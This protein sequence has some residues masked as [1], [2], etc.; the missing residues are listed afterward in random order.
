[1]KNTYKTRQGDNFE[2]LTINVE[3]IGFN[4]DKMHVYYIEINAETG[5]EVDW[6]K[7]R[8]DN[9][10]NKTKALFEIMEAGFNIEKSKKNP[11]GFILKSSK[12]Y[13][14]TKIYFA[15]EDLVFSNI[16]HFN[17]SS[18]YN[19]VTEQFAEEMQGCGCLS[20][21][22]PFFINADRYE[23]HLD[24]FY[25][26][27]TNTSTYRD[28]EENYI[29]EEVE[30]Y[31]TNTKKMQARINSDKDQIGWDLFQELEPDAAYNL[32]KAGQNNG[33]YFFNGCEYIDF[34]DRVGNI[35]TMM[36]ICWGHSHD[37]Q[38]PP[39]TQEELEDVFFFTVH[40][41]VIE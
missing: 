22:V 19:K 12:I 34:L 13:E 11:A 1:M 41:L 20:W 4:K 23:G 28:I 10:E 39:K 33:M 31:Y 2:Q 16:S 37:P 15:I 32:E 27:K 35:E 14:E 30:D 9:T 8:I 24:D 6:G 29:I 38:E 21:F 5:M 26:Y 25:T 18:N 7:Q 36:D 3:K 17:M 40:F